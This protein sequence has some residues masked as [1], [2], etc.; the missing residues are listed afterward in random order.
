MAL[1]KQ[2]FAMPVARHAFA[3]DAAIEHVRAANSSRTV[4]LVVMHHG[5]TAAPLHQQPRLGAVK[6][7]PILRRNDGNS[8]KPP[9]SP[10]SAPRAN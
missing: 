3:D 4:A 9:K 5:P 10:S 2:R 8:R 7:S 1:R 6:G